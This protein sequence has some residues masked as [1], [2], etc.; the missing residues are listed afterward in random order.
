MKNILLVFTLFYLIACTAEQNNNQSSVTGV[1]FHQKNID[2]IF[3]LAK[4]EQKLIM[5]DT[6]SDG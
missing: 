3:A 1:K 4:S 2:E 5:V 6:Y